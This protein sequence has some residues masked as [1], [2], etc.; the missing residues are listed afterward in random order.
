MNHGMHGAAFGGHL[1]TVE[2]FIYRHARQWNLGLL[3][4]AEGGH[5]HIVK[6]F[7]EKGA[8]NFQDAIDVA[9]NV[10]VIKYLIESNLNNKI[11]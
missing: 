4:A 5:L 2:F 6:F 11:R 3:G 1:D 9:K 8:D 7:V 10:H